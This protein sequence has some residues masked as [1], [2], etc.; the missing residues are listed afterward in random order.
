MPPRNKLQ[1]PTAGVFLPLLEPARYKGAY[2]GRG[3]GK[4]HF[5]GGLAIEDALRAPGETGV[6]LRMVCIR[7]V[8]KSLKESAKRLIEDKISE[9]GLTEAMG[10]KVYR[11]VIELPGDGIMTFTGMQDHTADSVK[12]LEGFDRAWVEEAQS[13]SDRSMTLLRPTIRKEGS[14]LWFSWNPARPTDPVD[15][16]LRGDKLPTGAKV[17]RANWSDNPWLPKTLEQ[18]RRDALESEPEKYPHIWE[19]EYATVLEGAYYAKHLTEAQLTGRIGFFAKDPL[20]PVH[21][22]WDLGGTSGRSDATAIWLVQYVGP[23]VRVLDY[24]EAVGQPFEAHV[25]WLKATGYGEAICVLPHDGRAH[26]TVYSVTPEG[27]LRKAG[28]VVDVVKNQGRGAALQR[29][30]A[31]RQMFP[32]VRF[33]EETTKGGREA[34]GWYHEKRDEHRQIGLGPNHDWASHGADAFGYLALGIRKNSGRLRDRSD[35]P[36]MAECDYNELDY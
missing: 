22:V 2:G 4:S 19:G 15:M 30:D 7:E 8:Q 5:F 26:D 16:L 23:E 27:Y 12:S 18:E 32:Q 36:R 31:T 14:E 24:Y 1:I 29:I 28:F 35:L 20:L 34:L 25:N 9:F 33:N 11:E 13:L 6:G 21:A 10:F 17:V 3:S